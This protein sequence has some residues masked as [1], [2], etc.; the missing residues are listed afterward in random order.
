MGIPEMPISCTPSRRLGAGEGFLAG[1][2]ISKFGLSAFIL[3]PYDGF[4]QSD[5]PERR[6]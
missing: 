2:N 5:A 1:L 6:P 4:N 3:I